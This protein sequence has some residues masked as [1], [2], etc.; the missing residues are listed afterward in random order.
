MSKKG[1][2]RGRLLITAIILVAILALNLFLI[3]RI[4]N[5]SVLWPIDETNL[6]GY[7]V[8]T[9]YFLATVAFLLTLSEIFITKGL[10]IKKVESQEKEPKS[11]INEL[12]I[13][14]EKPPTRKIETIEEIPDNEKVL[15]ND[16]I[17]EPEISEEDEEENLDIEVVDPPEPLYEELDSVMDEELELEGNE[18][19]EQYDQ[20]E[21]GLDFLD[22]EVLSQTGLE[23]PE[24]DAR[25][26]DDDP[27]YNKYKISSV[28]QEQTEY[29]TLPES[30]LVNTLNEFEVLVND[31]RSRVK[32]KQE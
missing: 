19:I 16:T 15:E 14:Y 22:G 20:V 24:S 8:S 7:L 28:K 5:V 21:T 18:I 29:P 23:T 26:K 11:D 2:Y 6:D 30:E 10:T 31:L 17:E 1:G 12:E 25:S 9:S 32:K 3:S 27:Y 13:E 4:L